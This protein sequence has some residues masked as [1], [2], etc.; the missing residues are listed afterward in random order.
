MR[1]RLR[2]DQL[3][4]TVTVIGP[5]PAVILAGLKV[6]VAP[7]G[8]PATARPTFARRLSPLQRVPGVHDQLHPVQ[9]AVEVRGI[10]HKPK[11][12]LTP[13]SCHAVLERSAC[14]PFIKERRME[15]INAT[16]LCRKSGQWGTQPS[17][18]VLEAGS[19]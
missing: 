18:P 16:S 1:V 2:H 19:S 7:V 12:G 6:D 15:C 13:I 8:P 9:S 17:L 4:L 10:P 11:S 3:P 14:A 5:L